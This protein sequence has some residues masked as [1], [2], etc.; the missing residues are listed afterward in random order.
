MSFRISKNVE[1]VM[2]LNNLAIQSKYHNCLKTNYLTFKYMY[3]KRC[4][5]SFLFGLSNFE[6]GKLIQINQ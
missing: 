6:R 1:K 4:L 2:I 3:L 5:R